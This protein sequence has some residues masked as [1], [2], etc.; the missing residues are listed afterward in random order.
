[1]RS[2]LLAMIAALVFAGS[3]PPARAAA[4]APPTT[5]KAAAEG[6]AEITIIRL[7]ETNRMKWIYIGLAAGAVA[8][9]GVLAARW[10]KAGAPP[11]PPAA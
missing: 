7:E 6:D 1:M 9:T 4:D 3:A 8:L 2:V 5:A 10:A 11:A